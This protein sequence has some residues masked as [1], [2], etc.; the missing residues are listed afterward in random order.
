MTLSRSFR[1]KILY[2]KRLY[3]AIY[4]ETVCDGIES[5][6]FLKSSFRKQISLLTFPV[7]FLYMYVQINIDWLKGSGL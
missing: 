5:A 4:F 2:H 6:Q 7:L 3:K 1:Q